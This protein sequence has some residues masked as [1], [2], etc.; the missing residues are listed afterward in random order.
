MI[1]LIE[2]WSIP[3]S[4]ASTI[5][6]EPSLSL[7]PSILSVL[8]ALSVGPVLPGPAAPVPVLHGED[9]PCDSPQ[10]GEDRRLEVVENQEHDPVQDGPGDSQNS[11]VYR[12]PSSDERV[13]P[14][15]QRRDSVTLIVRGTGVGCERFHYGADEYAPQ[16]SCRNVEQRPSVVPE[17]FR[18]RRCRT[19]SRYAAPVGASPAPVPAFRA[20]VQ[21]LVE[22]PAAASAG[23]E[24]IRSA[25]AAPFAAVFQKAAAP[26]AVMDL[27]IRVGLRC[28]S[29]RAFLLR[30]PRS[31]PPSPV[32][33]PPRS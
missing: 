14:V 12:F 11:P 27:L 4:G 19:D 22:D 13:E 26:V 9:E 2:P 10:K 24:L 25:G 30:H 6:T 7:C 28:R 29:G 32:A 16:N 18:G 1:S 23:I 15:H 3:G 21:G 17:P 5:S 20:P 31:A 33:R 8:T